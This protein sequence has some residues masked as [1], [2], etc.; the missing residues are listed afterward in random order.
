[1]KKFNRLIRG[2]ALFAIS[3]SLLV[4]CSK[5]EGGDNYATPTPNE[6]VSLSASD[7]S[8]SIDENPSQGAALGRVQA[9]ASSGTPNFSIINQSVAGAIA[10]SSNSGD[11][12]V[13]DPALFDFETRQQITATVRVSVGNVSEEVTVTI[14]INDV[15]EVD[16]ASLTLWEGA[17]LTFSKPN[18]GSPSDADNQ[19]RITDN[20]WLTRGDLGILYNIA[21]EGSA[22]NDSSPAGTEW[23]QGSF[24]DL[25]TLDFT[26]FRTACPG[27]KPK[28]VVGIPM[29]LHLIQDDLYIEITI[30][31]WAQGKMGGFTY[32][33]STP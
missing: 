24:S 13:A 17:P 20:V 2:L 22:N 33:R 5:D 8:S 19:D 9:T 10:V 23:A 25:Q 31:S 29:V 4:Q 32:T 3:S 16:V 26:S 7:F 15:S 11:I 6:A 14:T 27:A 21:T 30:T 12:T 28:N 1:M 18:G